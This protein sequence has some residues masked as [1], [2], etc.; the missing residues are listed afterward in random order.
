MSIPNTYHLIFGLMPDGKPFSFV[1]YLSIVSCYKVNRPDVINCYYEYEPSGI[2]W[3]RATPYL[4]LVRI[5]SPTHIHGVPL[6]HYA[7][8][9]DVLRLEILL[10][11]GGIYH[12]VDVLCIRP[13]EPLRQFEVVLGEECGAGLCNAV[14][15]ARP[16]APFLARWLARYETFDNAQW[17]YHSVQVPRQL[18]DEAPELVHVLDYKKF[19]WPM[20]WQEDLRRFFLERDSSYC[21]ESYC[22]HLWESFTWPHLRD[23]TPMHVWLLDS[24]FCRLASRCLDADLIDDEQE[25]DVII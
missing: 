2:W 12:D 25:A 8:R 1:H 16:G 18:A 4:N 9:A 11:H 3:E 13:F 15:L 17:N 7:H 19:F 23:L 20:Y 6:I 22:V 21:A 24:E 5:R 10:E 14:I